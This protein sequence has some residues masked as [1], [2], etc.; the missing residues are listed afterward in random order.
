MLL[1]TGH[2]SK[3]VVM[4]NMYEMFLETGMKL[5]CHVKALPLPKHPTFSV[6]VSTF[7]HEFE[8]F[9]WTLNLDRDCAR[10]DPPS[11]DFTQK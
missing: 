10:S 7:S 9:S 3:N 8:T 6:L 2:N 4:T 1:D 5:H 11:P